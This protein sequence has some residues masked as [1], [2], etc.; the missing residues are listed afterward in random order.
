MNKN[1][2]N[3]KSRKA[4]GAT[5][6][7]IMLA[8]VIIIALIA[9][10]VMGGIPSIGSGGK[11]R[12]NNAYWESAQIGITSHSIAEDGTGDDAFLVI[13]NNFQDSIK[14]TA[15]TFLDDSGNEEL[16]IS[17][18]TLTA[19]DETAI[20]DDDVG[21][22]CGDAATSYALKVSIAY[23]HLASGTNYTF[24]GTELLE[25]RCGGG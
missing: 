1:I 14:I 13:R 12:A 22:V 3:I 21:D 24:V 9:I 10:A 4:Q 16:D 5:E 15:I 8:I 25:G 2:F 7:L 11:Q 19:G 17:E 6:Y 20:T 18:T 23:D